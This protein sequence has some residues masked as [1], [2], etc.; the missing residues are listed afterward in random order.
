MK[1]PIKKFEEL[2]QL[3]EGLFGRIGRGIS[4][5]LHSAPTKT[6]PSAQSAE[7]LKNLQNLYG[8]SYTVDGFPNKYFSGYQLI[9]MYIKGSVKNN[10]LIKQNKSK[11]P[12]FEF[13]ELM[14]REPFYSY[15]KDHF[16]QDNDDVDPNAK[17]TLAVLD[18]TK[19]P[20]E[21]NKQQMN[22][23]EISN[24]IKQNPGSE[25]VLLI[26]NPENNKFIPLKSSPEWPII[27]NLL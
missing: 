23:V 18:R 5:F 16:K 26:L 22:S 11:K 1:D 9:Q 14:K 27:N 19:N 20:I 25:N 15:L 21:Y 2:V 7:R 12:K 8:I 13:K 10:T 3:T 6:L 4:S 17:L 24:F